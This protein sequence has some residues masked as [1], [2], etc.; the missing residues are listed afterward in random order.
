MWLYV[1][2]VFAMLG[3]IQ[4]KKYRAHW[5]RPVFFWISYACLSE[6]LA[7]FQHLFFGIDF[8]Q[9]FC[10]HSPETWM[11]C[12]SLKSKRNQGSTNKRNR[13]AMSNV[14]IFLTG[15]NE[16]EAWN[17]WSLTSLNTCLYNSSGLPLCCGLYHMNDVFNVLTMDVK[18]NI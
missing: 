1:V 11:K 6:D 16:R 14:L 7:D 3:V 9:R 17:C 10:T 2:P 4:G 5:G 18:E 12:E 13:T 8:D 15:W